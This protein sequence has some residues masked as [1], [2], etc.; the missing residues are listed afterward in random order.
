MDPHPSIGSDLGT[1]LP[2]GARHYRA[3]VGPPETYDLAGAMQFNLLTSLGLREH[4]SLLDIGCGSLR[5]G[6]L[7]IMYLLP[8]RYYGIEPLTWLLQEGIARHLDRGLLKTRRPVFS[9]DANFTLTGFNR[10]FDFLLAQSVFSHAPVPQ[11]ERCLAQARE[12]MTSTSLFAATFAEGQENYRGHAWSYPRCVTYQ[13]EFMS[14]LVE[15]HGLRCTPIGWSHLYDQKWL[16]ITDPS[17]RHVSALA[18]PAVLSTL[19][20]QLEA[21]RE[22]LAR[23]E[24]HPYVRLGLSIRRLLMKTR[25]SLA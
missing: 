23:L 10:T 17:C 6:R 15:K 8:D 16:A 18:N 5:A 25:K 4:H 12:V 11:I 14:R 3:F 19:R 2:P 7:L 9:N 13:M 24:T 20:F 1:A 21:Y 22:R